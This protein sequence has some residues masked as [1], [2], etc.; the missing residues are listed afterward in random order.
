ML[1]FINVY[2]RSGDTSAY[3]VNRIKKIFRVKCGHMG[4]LDPLASGVLPVAINQASRMFDF[5]LDKEKTYIAEFDF[6]YTTPSLDLETEPTE[7]SDMRVSLSGIER[8]LPTF[9]GEISQIPPDYSAKCVDGVKA[10]KLARRGK[11]L[12]LKPKTVFI[13]SVKALGQT[14]EN[15][16]SFEIVCKGGTYIRSLC[17]DIATALGVFGVMTKLERTKSGVFDLSNAHTLDEIENSADREALLIPTDAAVDYE[18]L[19]LSDED[20][21]HI[22]NGLTENYPFTDGV[23]RAYSSGNFCGIMK[24]NGGKVNMTYIRDL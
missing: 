12:D 15:R 10:Y 21:L 17:R 16:F 22:L 13:K 5:L 4:T 2:K 6:S 18:K 1:G 19:Y 23:Y 3:V 7:F 14:G 8:V 11:P 24:V 20:A 9:C